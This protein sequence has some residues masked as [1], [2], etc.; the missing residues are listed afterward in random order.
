MIASVRRFR[1]SKPSRHQRRFLAWLPLIQ[2]QAGFAFRRQPRELRQEL[3]AEVVVNA[4]VAFQRLVARRLPAR[5]F[6]TPLARYAIR[7]VRAGRRAGIRLNVRDVS[8]EH[9]QRKKNFTVERLDRFDER[10]GS[11]REVLVE[12]RRTGPAETAAARIDIADWFATLPP[13]KRAIARTLATGEAAQAVAARFA[14]SSARISQLRR[15]FEQAWQ[16]FQGETHS[17]PTQRRKPDGA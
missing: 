12:D 11:W 4:Y 6:P 5:A 8:S 17:N 3:V 1:P 16:E 9:A 2:K 10:S 7:Q 14:V 13:R 15:E